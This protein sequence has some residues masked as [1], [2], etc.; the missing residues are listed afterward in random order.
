MERGI[1]RAQPCAQASGSG[2][3]SRAS[4]SSWHQSWVRTSGEAYS[5]PGIAGRRRVKSNAASAGS[6][7]GSMKP[8]LA[9]SGVCANAVKQASANSRQKASA[10]GSGPV[11]SRRVARASSPWEELRAKAASSSCCT[12]SSVRDGRRTQAQQRTGETAGHVDSMREEMPCRFLMAR[13]L[14]QPCYFAGATS[15]R[16]SVLRCGPPRVLR[17]VRVIGSASHPLS[18]RSITARWRSAAGSSPRAVASRPVW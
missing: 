18:R 3:S 4:V 16:P 14:L 8:V 6:G 1:D 9:T 13:W 10:G 12:S 15:A 5:A 2:R 17:S 7:T 11:P